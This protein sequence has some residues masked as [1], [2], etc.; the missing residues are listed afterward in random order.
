VRGARV[1]NAGTLPD[2]DADLDVV[3]VE[4]ERLE[5][6]APLRLT[7]EDGTSDLSFGGIFLKDED[8][9]RFD[10]ALKGDRIVVPDVMRLVSSPWLLTCDHVA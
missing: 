4:G 2:L 6:T 3:S 5:I 9:F 7:S 1:D 10:A 8:E